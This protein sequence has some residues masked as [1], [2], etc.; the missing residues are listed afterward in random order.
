[1]PWNVF[2]E[3]HQV[4]KWVNRE[5]IGDGVFLFR[6]LFCSFRSKESR[7]KRLEQ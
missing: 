2:A 6:S 7:Q 5:N 4:T 3:R 1:M